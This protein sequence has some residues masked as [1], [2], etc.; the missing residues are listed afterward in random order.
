[1][2]VFR[3]LLQK[4]SD[5]PDIYQQVEWI[6]NTG[7]SYIDSGIISDNMTAFSFEAKFNTNTLSNTWN[8]VFMDAW[9]TGLTLG[10]GGN[11]IFNN[12]PYKYENNSNILVHNNNIYEF[13]GNQSYLIV[14]GV[15]YS[16]QSKTDYDKL[17]YSMQIFKQNNSTN[18]GRIS[19][20]YLRFYDNNVLVANFIPCYRKN[21]GVIGLYDSVNKNFHTNL[22]SGTFTKGA[23][24]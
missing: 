14:D 22:G 19:L 9:H 17:N 18:Y 4:S 13:A 15:Q 12:Y 24:V 23:D 5:L 1:M 6:G 8:T 11:V 10:R 7:S 2:S 21:D 3:S 20:Y 16:T